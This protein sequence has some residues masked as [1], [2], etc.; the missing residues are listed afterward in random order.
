MADYTPSARIRAAATAECRRVD[1]EIARVDARERD[2]LDRLAAV[3]QTRA[4]LER[5]RE[6]L[7]RFAAGETAATAAPNDRGLRAVPAGDPVRL[8]GPRIR[9][10]AVRALA[11]AEHGDAPIHYRDWYAL[12]RSSGYVATGQNPL[13]TFLSQI[14]RSPLVS[15]TTTKGVYV[16]DWE[17]LPRARARLRTLT[18]QL[19]GPQP[20]HDANADAVRVAR[21]ERTTALAEMRKLERDIDEMER[22]T[23][24]TAAAHDLTTPTPAHRPPL[25]IGESR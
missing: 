21:E 7:A 14:R 2:L 11:A 10:H 13:A 8:R 16:M 20:A 25:Q 18:E 15:S 24:T 17:V 5:E 9:E 12:L 6:T 4:D 3:K 1:R 22:S 19:Q 23:D